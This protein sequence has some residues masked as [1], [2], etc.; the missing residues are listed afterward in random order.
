MRVLDVH[1]MI[2]KEA[3][4]YIKEEIKKA[5]SKKETVIKVIHGYNNG[6][7]I[8]DWLKNSKTLG[9]EV[10]EVYPD[11]LNSG[12]TYIYLYKKY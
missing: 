3:T 4:I 2:F 5:H 8:K 7:K 6:S 9:E 12:V 10:K 11:L 1:G